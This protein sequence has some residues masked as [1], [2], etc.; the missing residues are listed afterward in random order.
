M[1]AMRG[2]LLFLAAA[3]LLLSG[4]EAPARPAAAAVPPTPAGPAEPALDDAFA[5]A[6][7]PALDDTL[8]PPEPRERAAVVALTLP[9]DAPLPISAILLPN[10]PREYR[11][12]THEGIDFLVPFGT[13]VRAAAAGV[14]VRLDREY[15]DWS[16]EEQSA[17]L[18]EARRLG[19]TPPPTLD[20]LRGR[21]VWIDHGDG[22]L[23]RYAHLASVRDLDV[24]D[25]VAPGEVIGTVGASGDPDRV[26]HLHFEIRVGDSYL[27]ADA[28]GDELLYLLARAFSPPVAYRER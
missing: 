17:A 22:T 27:G 24:G 11:G 26:P 4:G 23:T 2:A 28:P 13:P 14:V 9:V 10:A 12:G 8:A 15:V 19:A 20:R 25:R 18:A 6:A 3:T 21:Q 7:R 16:E 1:A 5:S